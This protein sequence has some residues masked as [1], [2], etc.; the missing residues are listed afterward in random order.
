MAE[1]RN[2]D[3]EPGSRI[4]RTDEPGS[5]IGRTDEPEVE[6]HKKNFGRASEELSAEDDEGPEV[7]GH[8]KNVG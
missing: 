8:K 6:G 5:R 3:E 4:G 1:E 2:I 7:E